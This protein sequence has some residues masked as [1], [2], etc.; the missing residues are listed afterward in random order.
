MILALSA[1]EKAEFAALCA[2]EAC[3]RRFFAAVARYLTDFPRLVDGDTVATLMKECGVSEQQAI[4]AVLAAAFDLDEDRSEQEARL[5]RQYLPRSIR[6]ADAAAYRA[7]PYF[8]K[9]RVPHRRVGEWLL[10]EQSYAPYEGFVCGHLGREGDMTV[11]P[12]AYFTEEFS[13]PSVMQNG[14]EWMAIKP[15]EIETMRAP[16]ARANGHVL[17]AGLGMGYFAYMAARKENVKSVTVLERDPSVISLF[18]DELLPQFAC[19]D[20]I[21]V[22]QADALAY[23]EHELPKQSYDYIFADLWHDAG[24]GL[25]LYARLRRI[26]EAK[27]LSFDYWIEDMLLSHLRATLFAEIEEAYRTGGRDDGICLRDMTAVR[28]LLGYPALRALAP[29]FIK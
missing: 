29:S 9:I 25:P 7:D 14:V 13:F 3:N 4:V 27:G 12:I 10:T 15:N 24:D 20:K 19:R 23:M 16:V 22:V 11:P 18:S 6:R 1:T 21:R 8:R 17:T 2:T 28:T 26:E 5:C